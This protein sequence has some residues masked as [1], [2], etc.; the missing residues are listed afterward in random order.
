MA[1]KIV[2]AKKSEEK[3]E[4]TAGTE[5]NSKVPVGPVKETINKENKRQ[6]INIIGE[7]ALKGSK[8]QEK[9]T[10]KTSRQSPNIVAVK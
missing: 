5:S 2:D 10:S 1:T 7:V 3:V 6:N 9:N 4:L 8:K